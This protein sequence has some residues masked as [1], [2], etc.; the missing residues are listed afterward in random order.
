MLK[1]NWKILFVA[2]SQL[3]DILA[4]AASASL[5]VWLRRFSHL[6]T[7]TANDILL[8]CFLIFMVVYMTIAVMMGL[9]RGSFHLSLSLQNMIMVRGYILSAL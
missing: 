4:M 9:Y 7:H 3:I 1:R 8:T 6:G 5:V 2:I